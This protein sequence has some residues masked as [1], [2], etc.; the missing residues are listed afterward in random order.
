MPRRK[1]VRAALWG[2]LGLAVLVSIDLASRHAVAYPVFATLAIDVRGG[3]DEAIAGAHVEVAV[4]RRSTG[5]PIP[6][7]RPSLV[8]EGTT[9]PRGRLELSVEL[10]GTVERGWLERTLRSF[11]EDVVSRKAA[12][13]AVLSQTVVTARKPGWRDR[14]VQ[15]SLGHVQKGLVGDSWL[16]VRPPL[17]VSV[18]V[19]LER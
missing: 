2:G 14:T 12:V 10:P 15:L 5:E 9:D 11:G 7:F 4:L 6:V 18:R 19:V 17:A 1:I 13:A 16:A 3:A 8:G